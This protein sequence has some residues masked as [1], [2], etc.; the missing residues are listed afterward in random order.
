MKKK[1]MR[2]LAASL[3]ILI[4]VCVGVMILFAVILSRQSEQT[5]SKV[6]NIYM[7][8]MSEKISEH[9]ETTINLRIAQIE[10][11]TKDV[12]P[13][14]VEYG[15]DMINE[16]RRNAEIRE[17]E[18]L[19]L[20]NQN[21]DLDMIYGEELTPIYPEL[22]MKS[23]SE[24]KKKVTVALNQSEEKVLLIGIPV[25]YSMADGS[26]SIALVAGLPIEYINEILSLEKTDSL[27]YSHI[28]RKD[29]NY[30]IRNAEEYGNNYF[31]QI[32][33]VFSDL[34]GQNHEQYIEELKNAM[35]NGV[36]YSTVL[37]IGDERR[38]M[39]C[40]SLPYSEWFLVTIMPYGTLDET[41]NSLS[42]Q[43]INMLIVCIA[44]VL[45]TLITIFAVYFKLTQS[46]IRELETTRQEAIRANKA[47]SEFLS[48][49]SHD[50]RTPMNAIVGMTS[51]ASAN[52][53]NKQQVEN[54]LKKITLS[55]KHL[56]GLIN[57]ILD[58]SKIESGK[59]ILNMYQ[60]SLKEVLDSLVNIIQ[61]QI[62]AKKQN[63]DVFI[64]DIDYE[65]VWCDRV[66]LS[67]VLLN[68]I[69][70]A[71]KFTPDEGTIHV[72]LF[73]EPSPISEKFVRLHISV[74]DSGIGMSKEFKEKIFESFTRED[75]KRVHKTEGTGLGM[76][77]TKHIVDAMFG[78]I[79]VE[80]ELG[81]G[82]EFN[83]VLDLEKVQIP[84]D[85]MVLPNW[86]ILVVDDDKQL[87]ESAASSLKS[88]GVNADCAFNGEDALKMIKERH[89]KQ[90][91]YQ[92]IL[93]D[94]QLPGL[95][96]IETARAIN[97]YIEENIPILLISAYDW[98][99]IE[100]D[101]REA[102]INGFISKP[103][104]KST[105]FYAL[106]QYRSDFDQINS[107][108]EEKKESFNGIKILVAEDNYLNW[109]IASELLSTLGLELD[110]AENGKL[111]VDMFEDSPVGYYS[112]ILMDIRMPVMTGYE[113]TEEI[114]KSDRADS[115]IPIIAMTADAF[116]EDAQ[117][118]FE[119]GMNAH[120]AKP[121]DIKEVARQLKKHIK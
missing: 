32:E 61:P 59:L 113:A 37:I 111:C 92:I 102:G 31:N 93:L 112:A 103:L 14:K 33:G 54:C 30:V 13:D 41:I 28:I 77:I 78:T 67:Q 81:K 34:N 88:I 57:D 23:L 36:D 12:P 18:Y 47:K 116:A 101:A 2:F 50:I 53:D 109:E 108:K 44:V 11:I 84:R 71:I 17:F 4:I 98:S 63:F 66:R 27:T 104:F 21:G 69:S 120:I 87:C 46:H 1:T 68:L 24:G 16:L 51:I 99:G 19:A 91:G 74:K 72:S 56:L 42:S 73:E 10:T 119:C 80:S 110:H 29:G 90:D 60:V 9:F 89:D 65:N 107:F 76:A 100:D 45:V 48:N 105:L 49:M 106:N 118:C 82:T 85:E 7:S 115:D 95:D 58:M 25:S 64:H 70:N 39:Y 52:M 55:S 96:G 6:G 79:E 15:E 40:S 97:N 38:H 26:D 117:R 3:A 22:F 62:K 114:R 35:E 43:R 86:N 5:I 75:S 83:V 20:Y 121:I 8:G 94:W